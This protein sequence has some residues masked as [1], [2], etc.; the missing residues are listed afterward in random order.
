[1]ISEVLKPLPEPERNENWEASRFDE[2]LASRDT[3]SLVF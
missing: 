2:L 1:M 3:P